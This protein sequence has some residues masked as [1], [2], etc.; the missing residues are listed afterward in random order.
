MSTPRGAIDSAPSLKPIGIPPLQRFTITPR[1]IPHMGTLSE[2]NTQTRK[3]QHAHLT[4][5]LESQ[6]H[7]VEDEDVALSTR[8]YR[9]QLGFH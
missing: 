7:S 3:L 9:R 8:H 4:V 1:E 6:C 5:A 2:S